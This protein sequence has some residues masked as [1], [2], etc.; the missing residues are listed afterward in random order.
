MKP[1]NAHIALTIF[2][3]LF[4]LVMQ[5]QEEIYS[6][7]ENI[8]FE[9][10]KIEDDDGLTLR[11]SAEQI[12]EDENGIIWAVISTGLYRYNGYSVI[13]VTDYLA[14]KYHLK[15]GNEFGTC[16]YVENDSLIW[17]GSRRA[18]YKINLAT[19]EAKKI[20]LDSSVTDQN[21]R[22][23]ITLFEKSN[24][25]LYVGTAN[26]IYL[27]NSNTDS[28]IKGFLNDGVDYGWRMS[29]KNVNT[30]MPNV[31]IGNVW[32]AM[33][34]GFY[35]IKLKSGKTEQYISTTQVWD[36][37]HYYFSGERYDS[38]LLMPSYGMG[39]V[40]FNF[41][42][43]QFTDYH[44]NT[45]KGNGWQY[46]VIRAA[47]KLNDSLSLVNVSGIG[48]GLFNRLNKKYTFLNTPY[49]IEEDGAFIDTDRSGYAWTG[50]WGRLFRTTKPIIKANKHFKHIL[51]IASVNVNGILKYR[52]PLDGYKKL[53][54]ENDENNIEL[55]YSVTK[56]YLYNSVNYQYKIDGGAWQIPKQ[57]NKLTFFNLE[58]GTHTIQIKAKGKNKELARQTISFEIFQPFYKSIYFLPSILLF[59][60]VAG[61]S[62][63]EF[64]NKRNRK[65]A[66]LKSA[67]D[68]KLTELEAKALRSQINPHFIFNT[69]N[70]I[71]YFA[72]MKTK[73][74]TTDFITL[75][76]TLIRQVLE[77]SKQS[78]IPLN[79]EIETLIAY[80]E[81]EKLRFRN[82]FDYTLKVD[83]QI[84]KDFLI[85]PMIVQPFIENA[86]W[87][88]LMHKEDNRNLS[89]EFL[90][91]N[92]TVQ[93]IITDNGIGRK[94]AQ[95]ITKN[96]PL[97]TSLGI[98]ITHERLKK[99]SE[100][101]NLKSTFKIID[102]FDGEGK[103]SGTRV[104]IEF[105]TV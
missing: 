44:T 98:K 43:K 45:S 61:F 11:E 9:Q 48:F 87:H 55:V 74:E 76:S 57:S 89:I 47:I 31:E 53:R 25:T 17:Y 95:E 7:F 39:M 92:K 80:I 23:Y 60:F 93:C 41:N 82:S 73:E 12:Y 102:L 78:L 22:N 38:I 66:E 2:L 51:D 77:N 37:S 34:D 105:I 100:L 64:Q 18:L 20:V 8:R 24:D 88:G 28:I 54:L 1:A 56:P 86:I 50:K 10:V 42:T 81:I 26:G 19:P 70:S 99:L 40:E 6:N 35:K 63:R 75:F 21:Y 3:W 36:Y 32:T 14:T 85:P 68:K 30:I 84:P 4:T 96:K 69:L 65:N 29:S 67:F 5:C 15:F 79:E 83:E 27:I 49:V 104:I 91:K 59:V 33:G 90:R 71:K 103:S 101:Y 94:M 52:P 13:N 46:N 97:K 16:F 72:T 62:I 58:H